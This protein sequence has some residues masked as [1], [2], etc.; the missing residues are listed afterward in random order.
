[1]SIANTTDRPRHLPGCCTPRCRLGSLRPKKFAET[2]LSIT[3]DRLARLSG[4]RIPSTRL[5]PPPLPAGS[6]R[7]QRKV[8]ATGRIMVAGQRIKLGHHHR[9]TLVTVV[10]EGTHLRIVHDEEEPATDGTPPTHFSPLCQAEVR[11][12]S[13]YRGPDRGRDRRSLCMCLS[14]LMTSPARRRPIQQRSRPGGCSARS[15]SWRSSR[16]TRTPPTVRKARSCAT[17]AFLP[18]HRVD[19]GTRRQCAGVYLMHGSGAD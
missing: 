1:M 13:E 16:S 9:G 18:H 10:I 19:T 5:P 7:A 3:T 4:A 14:N 6:L 8:H 17:W 2:P 12:P 11:H 15:T